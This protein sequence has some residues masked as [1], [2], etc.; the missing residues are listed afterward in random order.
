MTLLSP[1]PSRAN[2]PGFFQSEDPKHCGR[3]LS[4]PHQVEQSP[5]SAKLA[6][7]LSFIGSFLGFVRAHACVCVSVQ[8][9]SER[10]YGPGQIL[11]PGISGS[12][13]VVE[14]DQMLLRPRP[15][16]A[17]ASLFQ[18]T[19]DSVYRPQ[20]LPVTH[21]YEL[22]GSFFPTSLHP[23]GHIVLPLK[24]GFLPSSTTLESKTA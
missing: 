21:S 12:K 4:Y 23:Q 3:R 5:K 24:Q 19:A 1:V 7:L 11:L 2:A 9:G 18:L 14:P 20:G 22:N 17:A 6:P 15:S 8:G 13:G 10:G 16:A